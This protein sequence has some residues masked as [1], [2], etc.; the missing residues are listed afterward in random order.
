[1]TYLWNVA[2]AV[3][4]IA[5]YGTMIPLSR[6]VQYDNIASSLNQD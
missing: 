1:M 6:E 2:Y 3:T 4:D 5:T